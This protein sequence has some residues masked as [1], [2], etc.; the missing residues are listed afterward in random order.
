[1]RDEPL[2]IELHNTAYADAGVPVDGL[3]TTAS[4]AAWLTAIGTR[5]PLDDYPAGALPSR[6]ELVELRS[7]VRAVLRAVAD[8]ERPDAGSLDAINRA[9]SGAPWSPMVRTDV[10][11]ELVQRS[12][13]HGATRA[14][15][16]LAAF[17]RDAIELV[18]G[19]RRHGLRACGAPGCVLLFLKD[20]PRRAW[21]C[22]ACGNRARQ[23]RHYQRVRG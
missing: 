5:L 16:V 17:A 21:C 14:D 4:A 11:G 2:A 3:A 9:S 20:H 13:F 1:L 10:S 15:V 22:N 12:S 8:G 6:D 18:S 7:A 23:A 19:P